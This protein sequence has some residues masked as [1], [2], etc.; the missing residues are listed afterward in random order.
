MVCEAAFIER[1]WNDLAE[2]R[3]GTA[4]GAAILRSREH[5]HASSTRGPQASR[6]FNS[7]SFSELGG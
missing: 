4:N 7:L 5:E 6:A 1:E 2:R 3:D